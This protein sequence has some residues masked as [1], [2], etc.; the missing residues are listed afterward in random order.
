MIITHIKADN[1]LKYTHLELTDIP[2]QGVIAISGENESGKS[3]IGETVCFALFGRTFSIGEEEITRV[4][5]WGESRCS[6]HLGFAIGDKDYEIARFLDN[7]GNHGARLYPAGEEEHPFAKG[8]NAVSEALDGLLGYQF[9]EFV[10]S[11]YL[12]QREITTPH[13]HSL[14]IKTMA[15]ISALEK[16]ADELSAGLKNEQRK[17]PDID[18]QINA[19]EADIEALKIKPGKLNGLEIDLDTIRQ[20]GSSL[21]KNNE[22]LNKASQNYRNA[23]PRYKSAQLIKRFAELFSFLSLAATVATGAAWYL[24]NRI[25]D[26][27]YTSQL[28]VL[29][30]QYVPLWRNQYISQLQLAFYVSALFILLFWLIRSVMKRKIS[31]L[32][33]N[34]VLLAE[35]VQAA[36]DALDLPVDQNSD[37][38]V[39]PKADDSPENEEIINTETVDENSEKLTDSVQAETTIESSTES[40]IQ[41]IS[42]VDLSAIRKCKLSKDRTDVLVRNI[43][44]Q[45][46]NRLSAQQDTQEALE[47]SLSNEQDRLAKA[48]ALM[49]VTSNLKEKLD[50]VKHR[51]QLREIAEELIIAATRHFSQRFNKDLREMASRTLPLFTEERYEHLHIGDDLS[52]RAFSSL[53]R[54][55]MDLEEISSGTQRQ[56]ML[57]VRLALSQE[58]VNTTGGSDQFIFLDEP[59]AFFD[60]TRTRNAMAILP[61]LSEEIRQIW[62]IAQSFP[63]DTQYDRAIV[64]SRKYDSLPQQES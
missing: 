17:Q 63:E 32:K 42:T 58:L 54:D 53:K 45:L 37:S 38:F 27:T 21:Q 60:E 22:A 56:I 55:Y 61:K 36:S 4:I 40:S 49:G 12:A 25:P 52:V 15:G 64:C 7:E 9:E 28:T 2:R 47:S 51:I 59:F 10:E 19:V 35:Q 24:F 20:R 13:P 6:V 43:R 14:A 29:I 1:L 46:Q 50:E 33:K 23:L 11:F 8:I 18:E 41:S 44:E 39:E 31:I 62:V 3:T 26:S 48:D 5:R 34:C 30:E 57:A 16:V